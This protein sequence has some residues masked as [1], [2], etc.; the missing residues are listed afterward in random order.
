MKELLVGLVA[1]ALIRLLY[2]LLGADFDP[3]R[4]L[5][6][7]GNLFGDLLA[8]LGLALALWWLHLRWQLARS[9]RPEQDGKG[10]R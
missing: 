5:T 1:S 4:D 2:W 8:F 9:S 6:D 10:V 3:F 7:L